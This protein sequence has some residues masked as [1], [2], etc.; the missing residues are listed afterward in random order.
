MDAGK[1]ALS[2]PA[3]AALAAGNRLEA[4]RI[5]RED[6]GLGLREAKELVEAHAA[7][8]A[9]AESPGDGADAELPL[10]AIAFLEQGQMIAAVRA[11]R[12]RSGIG[13]KDAKDRVDRYLAEH[14][15]TRQRFQHL[16]ASERARWRSLIVLLL[17]AAALAWLAL[18]G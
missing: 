13:L 2:E 1:P 3:R 7:G 4:I 5:V 17:V 16:V 12:E 15:G 10:A 8:R 18:R 6:S 11:T 14:A 9:D